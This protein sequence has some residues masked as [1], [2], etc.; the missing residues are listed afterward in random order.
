MME[1]EPVGSERF[2]QFLRNISLF[3]G[4]S[5]KSLLTLATASR[6]KQIPRGTYI[7]FQDD[8]AS[9]VFLVLRGAVS[10]QL[11]DPEGRELVI[12][13]IKPEECFGELGIITGRPRSTSAEAID[14]TDLLL[15]PGSIFMNVLK[16]EPD[17]ALNL[18]QVTARR[19]QDSSKREE[20]LAFHDAQ[21]RLAQQLLQLD[22]MSADQGYLTLSQEDLA[23]RAGLTRQT[24]ATILGRWR[25]RGWLLTGRGHIVL[26]NRKELS[27]LVQNEEKAAGC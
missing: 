12:N 16:Q 20:S 21:Q 7:F 2:L 14:E 11:E 3:N 26:L 18:L 1:T 5:Q 10:I 25:Q 6:L 19:L 8:A 24:A 15:I 27:R 23:Q 9:A 17:L 4:V 13:E 22:Q